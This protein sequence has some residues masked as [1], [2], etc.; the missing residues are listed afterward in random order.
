M[1]KYILT[2]LLLLSF[3]IPVSALEAEYA[4]APEF[5]VARDFSNGISLVHKNGES[6][7]INM[8]GAYVLPFDSSVK[9]IR[10]NGL[11]MVVGEND[12]AA[13][14]DRYGNQK[15]AFIYDT[16]PVTHDKTREKTYYFTYS[17][18][19]GDGKSTWVPF[20]RD[21]KYGYIDETGREVVPPIYGFAGGFY[22]GIARISSDGI[23]SQYGTYM[24][25]KYGLILETGQEIVPPDSFWV[26]GQTDGGYSY[27]SNGRGDT[28]LASP[29]GMTAKADAVGYANIGVPFL[30]IEDGEGR[31]GVMDQGGNCVIPL[32]FYDRLEM[33]GSYSFIVNN[34]IVDDNNRL[35]FEAPEGITLL[36]HFVS[37]TEKSHLVKM[38]KPAG[39]NIEGH[40]LFGFVSTNG[41]VILEP[42]FETVFDMGEGLI[43]AQ[44]QNGNHL[45]DYLGNYLCTLHGDNCGQSQNGLFPITD[46]DTMKK[47]YILNPLLCPKVFV[48]GEQIRTDVYP[49][50]ENNRTLVPMRAVFEKMG[51]EVGWDE[52]TRTVSVKRNDIT[53]TLQIGAETM[54]KN[55]TPIAIGVPAKIENDRTL[56]PLRAISE[57]INCNVE[58]NAQDRTVEI[59]TD[60][61]PESDIIMVKP[62]Y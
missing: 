23:L 59:R 53:V 41:N 1:K 29:S 20:S 31:R 62:F 47:G 40:V 2:L 8:Y 27:A 57:A 50:I 36:P 11:I 15:T 14:F 3:A 43:F 52:E 4:I 42:F 49:K 39:D 60:M 38:V 35:I 45:Y 26:A 18:E 55:D 5:D 56:V 21:K 22:D 12:L 48:D 54:Y 30:Y 61:P 24:N 32:D 17:L 6:A 33:A 13:F 10:S 7:V 16:Y 28:L 44:D 25:G 58:W 19:E 37:V 51:A 46:F 9:K 34:K